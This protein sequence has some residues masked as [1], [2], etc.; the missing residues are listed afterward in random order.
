MPKFQ[1]NGDFN[2]CFGGGKL[3]TQ[4]FPRFSWQGNI[5]CDVFQVLVE[6]GT[7]KG[8]LED[9]E[10]NIFQHS[11]EC[12]HLTCLKFQSF[13]AGAI[14]KCNVFQASLSPALVASAGCPDA[15]WQKASQK[16]VSSPCQPFPY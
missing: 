7:R 6:E 4:H 12:A 15:F 10:C 8:V 11:V 3:N 5:K 1:G 16:A 2:V 9:L 14:S 13:S